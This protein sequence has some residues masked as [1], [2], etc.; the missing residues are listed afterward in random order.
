MSGKSKSSLVGAELSPS[1]ANP[2]SADIGD[3]HSE[4]WDSRG[5]NLSDD[6][7]MSENFDPVKTIAKNNRQTFDG[8]E[9]ARSTKGIS[10]ADKMWTKN[11]IGL[12]S[13][14]AAVGLLYG[15]TGIT[16]NF[17]VYYYDGA[18]NLC[19]NANS[20]IFLAW[21]FKLLYAVLTDSFRPFGMRRIPYMM[22]GWGG[23]LF[24]LLVL[25]CTA[26]TLDASGW[27]GMLM[28][29]QA[30]VMLAD[31]PADGYSV[32]LGQMES[33]E[34]RGQILA[35]GQRIRFTF[36]VLA[37]V[38]QT[39]LMNGPETNAPNCAIGFEN[40]WKW[41]FSIQEYYG[42]MFCIV[43]V[44]FIP[45]CYLRE[46]DPSQFPRHTPKEFGEKIWNTMQNKT[47]LFILIYVA[48][49][50]SFGSFQNNAAIYLQYF[51]LK[52]T[53]FQAGIDTITTYLALVG[54]VYLFQKY[55]INKN[56]RTTKYLSVLFASLLALLW[57]LSFHD[58]GGLRNPWFTIFVDM[59]TVF[60][61]GIT[62]VLYSMAVIELAQKGLEAT[63]YELVVSVGNS[64]LTLSSVLSTQLLFAVNARPC[65]ADK[66]EDCS[67]D[68]VY[69]NSIEGFKAT[70]GPR[71]FS[72]YTFLIV[73]IQ[74]IA[75]IIFTPYLPSSKEECAAW[76]KQG[77]A[78]GNSAIRGKIATIVSVLIILYGILAA[79]LL[80]DDETS[81]M[82]WIGGEGC[83]N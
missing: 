70:N 44:L 61:S 19:A 3:D 2:M 83:P 56:W 24:I 49:I 23:V 66:Y 53:N 22:A 14:Y 79:I 47:T 42:F 80:L 28:T 64:A 6:S 59:D 30:F 4:R 38:I 73:G 7:R 39:L 81:C 43:F 1:I 37:G 21:N 13:Q 62:Q 71:K 33:A 9:D 75:M 17:C 8:I 51:V 76:R 65:T 10:L 29:L 67:S 82:E 32:E 74:I 15:M 5:S 34:V 60:A 58:S 54:G 77:E 52:M 48:G 16:T 36:C 57:P 68:E 69:I 35:T 18:A 78:A 27:I 55:L 45:V 50:N 20:F 12:Y 26:N 46:I 41:G 31:V 11:Y 72:D 63:T 40:C 25:A